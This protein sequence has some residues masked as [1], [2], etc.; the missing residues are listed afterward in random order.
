MDSRARSITKA[1]TWRIIATIVTGAVAYIFTSTL[2]SSIE[3]TV[4]VMILS[5]IAYYLH[6]RAWNKVVWGRERAA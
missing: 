6:E 5:T 2:R 1:V 4:T 3:L